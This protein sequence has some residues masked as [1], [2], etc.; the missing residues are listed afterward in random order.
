MKKVLIL[1]FIVGAM[2]LISRAETD[3]SKIAQWQQ[4]GAWGQILASVRTVD[5][6]GLPLLN[7]AGF[8][9]FQMGDR[10]EALNWYQRSLARDSDSRPA[11]YYAALIHKSE[12]RPAAAIPLLQ[13]LCRIAPDNAGYQQLLGDCYVEADKDPAAVDAYRRAF[14]LL[15][16]SVPL[17]TKLA[18]ALQRAKFA[19]QADTLLRAAMLRNPGTPSLLNSAISLAYSRKEYARCAMLCDSLIA[20]GRMT[21]RSLVC[22]LYSDIARPEFR[23]ATKMG[24]VL[25]GMDAGT[26]DVLYYTAIAHQKLGEWKK[27]DTLLRQ[28]VAK[29]LK[30]ELGN[31]YEALASGAEAQGQFM[32]SKAYYDTAYYLFK[33]PTTLYRA[34]GMLDAHGLKAEAQ[35]V[36]KRY[37]ALPKDRQDTAVAR[38]LKQRMEEGR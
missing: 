20:T 31:C 7:A 37:L 32:K 2:P 6:P 9:A 30:P 23:H 34:G 13:R 15:P 33:R 11:M 18:G 27:A 17:V 26:E 1:L 5:D 12:E 14:R 22:G 8:A 35:P 3:T 10:A 21:Y 4:E 38:Y 24:E 19:D 28:C 25:I 36:F 29:Y 16:G